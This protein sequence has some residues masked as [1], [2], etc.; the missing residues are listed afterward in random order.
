MLKVY[1]EPGNLKDILTNTEI[2]AEFVSSEGTVKGSAGCNSYFGSYKLNGGQLSI[3]GPVG[4][5][6][7]YCME[8][9]GIMDQEQE[10][11]ALIQLAESYDIDGNE[12]QINCS[13]QVLIFIT[14]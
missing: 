13:S 2:T 3:P 8:H 9:E 5:T 12:L 1:G 4:V 7:M 6:E 11:L 10:Y 14:D